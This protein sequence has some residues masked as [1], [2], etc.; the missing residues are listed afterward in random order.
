[1]LCVSQHNVLHTQLITL[2]VHECS[3][4]LYV[5]NC[6]DL[7]V[8]GYDP[9]KFLQ[10]KRQKINQ[11]VGKFK[12]PP[13]YRKTKLH[14]VRYVPCSNTLSNKR[15]CNEHCIVVRTNVS[16][17]VIC[18]SLFLSRK[19]KQLTKHTPAHLAQSAKKPA[20]ITFI[21]RTQLPLLGAL[22][23]QQTAHCFLQKRNISIH[24][25]LKQTQKLIYC[26]VI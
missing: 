8:Y 23:C 22:N 12:F 17:P 15:H 6:T 2:N 7:L 11:Y 20:I 1:M 14:Y 3:C 21:L 4:S 24:D 26:T 5:Y 18:L 25:N 13:N 10:R 16:F 19:S 9:N